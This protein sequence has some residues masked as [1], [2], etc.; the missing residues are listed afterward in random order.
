MEI[1]H[2]KK[3]VKQTEQARASNVHQPTT[4][5]SKKN[6]L[7]QPSSP[8]LR[9]S[10]YC[11]IAAARRDTSAEDTKPNAD[12]LAAAPASGAGA[13]AEEGAMKSC[14]DAEAKKTATARRSTAT[15]GAITTLR[16]SLRACE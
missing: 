5:L 9:P 15:R 6:C 2:D 13:G 11:I 8:K 4:D 10:I 14:A 12:T 1:Q 7:L 16:C 3:N